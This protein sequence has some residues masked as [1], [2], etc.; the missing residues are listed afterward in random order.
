M[1]QRPV[2]ANINKQSLN[3]VSVS[4]V[5]FSGGVDGRWSIAIDHIDQPIAQLF[6]GERLPSHGLMQCLTFLMSGIFG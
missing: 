4:S 2:C 3:F 1:N 6:K 5:S